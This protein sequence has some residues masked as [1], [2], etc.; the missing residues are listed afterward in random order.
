MLRD[1]IR[2]NQSMLVAF[3]VAFPVSAFAS[4]VLSDQASYLNATYATIVDYAAYLGTFGVMF[5]VTNRHRYRLGPDGRR[6][7]DPRS[8]FK[9]ILASAGIG[10][11]VYGVVR[12]TMQYYLLDVWQYEAYMSSVVAQA[13]SVIIYMVV[14]NL[15][16]RATGLYSPKKG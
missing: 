7:A 13:T 3:A 11:V 9:K 8:D 5:Y 4:D 1:Y 6:G 15:S 10:E 16:V 14:M 12:W 2:L